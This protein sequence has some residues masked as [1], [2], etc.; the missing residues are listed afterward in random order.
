MAP[1]VPRSAALLCALPPSRREGFSS[2]SALVFSGAFVGVAGH[3]RKRRAAGR[4]GR[5][6]SASFRTGDTSPGFILQILQSPKK[7]MPY[8]VRC[9]LVAH[10]NDQRR[11]RLGSSYPGRPAHP[12]R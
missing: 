7:G 11:A 12:S 2:S 9:G 6:L 5:P 8:P 10:Y 4:F 3:G 1:G